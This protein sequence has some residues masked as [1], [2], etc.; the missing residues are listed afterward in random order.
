MHAAQNDVEA[1]E[2][3]IDRLQTAV[4][5]LERSN[6]ELEEELRKGPDPTY[7]EAIAVRPTEPVYH[8]VADGVSVND[9]DCLV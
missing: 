6:I 4:S 3:E 9:F 7:S 5:H 1:I 8:L 2:L